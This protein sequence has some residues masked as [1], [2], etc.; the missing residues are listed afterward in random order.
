MAVAA[1]SVV[2]FDSGCTAPLMPSSSPSDPG[3]EPSRVS[4]TPAPSLTPSP[5]QTPTSRS[6]EPRLPDT[7]GEESLP[8]EL[9]HAGFSDPTVIDNQWF[10][11]V[12]GTRYVYRG[13]VND[14][15]A[16]PHSVFF[17]VTDLVKVID[18]IRAVVIY[19]QDAVDGQV[20]EAEIAFLAQDDLGNVWLL[21]EY[22]E[23]YEDGEFVAAPTWIHGL[24]GA[25]AG[26]LVK[27]DPPY[28][29]SWPQGWGPE[30]GWTDRARVFEAGSTTCV[31]TGCYQDVLVIDEFNPEEPDAHQLKYYAPGIGNVRVGWA[32]AREEDQEVL[33]LERIR[34]LTPSQMDDIRAAAFALEERGFE[35]SPDVYA[36]TLPMVRSPS[37]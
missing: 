4:L 32:G 15:G 18:G 10:P 19:D 13:T 36:Q 9:S 23:E 31:P 34:H 16:V 29:P 35:V 5:T 28:G 30:V 21:G 37:P 26:I 14:D 12:P 11:L 3:T 2:I 8:D 1:M 33:E 20:V 27:A 17:T 6:P 22:P 25:R 7:P 24:A